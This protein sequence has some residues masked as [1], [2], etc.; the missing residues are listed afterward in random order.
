TWEAVERAGIDPHTLRGS[1]T[2]TF[3]GASY[4][5]YSVGAANAA[6]GAEGHMITGTLSSVLSGRVAYL[7]GLEGPAV[8]LDT[9]CSSSLVALHLACQSLR[10]GESSLAVAGGVSVMATPGAFVGFSRQ[11]ALA[12]DGRCKAYSDA[13][14]GM[15]L[16]E[17][18]GLLLVERLSDARRNGHPVLA[19]VRGSAVNQDGASNGLTAPNGP[20]QQR[21]IRQALA[22]ARLAASDVDVVDGHGT[23]TALGDPIEAQALLTTYG[24]E[25]ERPLLLG[26]VKSNIGHTQMASGVASVIKMVLALQHGVVP[27]TLH[28]DTPSSHVDWSTGA[29]HLLTEPAEW[30]DTGRPRRAG[31]SSFGLSGTNAHTILEQAAPGEEPAVVA[32]AGPVPVVVSARGDEALRAQAARL[33]S[34][35]RDDTDLD[36]TDL[37][38][39]L[40]TSRSAFERR[41]AV[42]AG[43]HEELVRGLTALRDDL[44][45]AGLVRGAATRGRTAFL[46]SGQGSQ[47]LGMGRELYE[48]FPVFADA[49]DAVLAH[50][51]TELDRPL[52]DVM[53]GADPE[54]LSDTGYT[55]PALFALEVALFRLVSSWGVRPDFLAGHSIGE[56]AAAHVAGVLSL[57]DACTLVTAR[58]GLMRALPTG[59]VMVA[60]EATETEVLPL[61]VEGV[62][63]AAV[64]GPR[65]VVLAG[66]EDAVLGIAAA[67]KSKKL[68]VSHAFHSAHMDPVLDEFRAVVEGLSF[69]DPLIPIVASGEVTSPEYWVRHVRDAVRFADN[70]A[71]LREAGVTTF[72]ELGPD[73]VLC[74]LA[75]ETVDGVLLPALRRDR[76]EVPAIL[77]AVAG[78][79]VH[80]VGVDWPAYFAGGAHRIDLTTY[81]FQHQ[82]FWPDAVAQAVVAEPNGVDAEF[83]S[84]VE[85]ADVASLVASLDL[86]DDT[87]TAMVPALTSWR[88][89]RREQSTVDGWRYG[90]TWKPLSGM[91]TTLAGPWLVLVPRVDEWV[92]TVVESLGV[93]ITL[94]QVDDA[95]RAGLAERLRADDIRYSGVLSLLAL[96]DDYDGLALTTA[97]VQALGDAGVE[98]PLWCATRAA[99]SVGRSDHLANPVQAAVWGLGRVVSLEHPRRWGGLID[100]PQDVDRATARRVAGVLASGDEDQVAVRASG[101]YA[102]RLA[103]APATARSEFRPAGTVLVTGGTG[104]LGSQVARW[105]ARDGVE[106][107][108]L[109]SRRGP[110]APGA[111]DL[112]RDLTDLGARVAIVA[113][114]VA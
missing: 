100:L 54:P 19:V 34:V 31:V 55:Q 42:V 15:T 1:S 37:A 50:L 76:A 24:Q 65:S 79:H 90:V 67:W 5:D 74:G 64:N 113:C 85:R 61:L 27:K 101:V 92:D 11:R 109:V 72:L 75:R 20:S 89:K 25:R 23:G 83:W 96:A 33:L 51:D 52:R 6:D 103:H 81:P 35:L 22:N 99:V 41:A 60:V 91:T 9:A 111:D 30:P 98:A 73:S 63:I 104:G 39:S 86:D 62:S 49:L 10:N 66:D 69:H 110:D 16:A 8:T 26:S 97:A 80:G 47:R 95:D 71:A 84:A 40:A 43:D 77:A 29:I 12:K 18:V 112:A 106:S 48:R 7:F 56:I 59:G 87:V 94:L 44:P 82:R 105:L 17:G 3:I 4:Q 21:V 108:L 13:A 68:V 107:L 2:G 78:L 88:R 93:A 28:V 70:V 36:L 46:F 45:D 38:F 57:A 53:W 114:D 32:V 14:D 58:A 102:R